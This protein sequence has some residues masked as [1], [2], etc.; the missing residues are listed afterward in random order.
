MPLGDKICIQKEA[1]RRTR[2][3]EIGEPALQKEIIK[4]SNVADP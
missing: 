2:G 1:R 3:C 4:K